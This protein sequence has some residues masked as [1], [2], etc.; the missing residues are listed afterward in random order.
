MCR[1]TMVDEGKASRGHEERWEAALFAML[2]SSSRAATCPGSHVARAAQLV[3]KMLFNKVGDFFNVFLV[4][5]QSVNGNVVV[6]GRPASSAGPGCRCSS[7]DL[8][9]RSH[10]S[11][12]LHKEIH[13][14]LDLR[15]ASSEALGVRCDHVA[16]PEVQLGTRA[17][18]GRTM[19][20][21]EVLDGV[22]DRAGCA[23]NGTQHVPDAVDEALDDID[24]PLKSLTR[25][26]AKEAVDEVPEALKCSDNTAFQVVPD[27]DDAVAQT[28]DPAPKGLQNTLQPCHDLCPVLNSQ[29]YANHHNC[30]DRRNKQERPCSCECCSCRGKQRWNKG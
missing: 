6:D 4:P 29:D 5:C 7:P 8:R 28:D 25:Q 21:E 11:Q 30:D 13:R 26:A 18:L 3:A 22:D 12:W 17:F 2:D 14:R 10:D 23:P 16:R 9:R 27:V 24:S 19:E 1:G 20:A 15:H